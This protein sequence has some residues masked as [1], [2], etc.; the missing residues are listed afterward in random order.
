MVISNC[1]M[2][3]LPID[4]HYKNA[5]IQYRSIYDVCCIVIDGAHPLPVF[6]YLLL[7]R[8]PPPTHKVNGRCVPVGTLLYDERQAYLVW[9]EAW[10]PGRG[11]ILG[12][13][14]QIVTNIF[15]AFHCLVV[16]IA[17]NY[18]LMLCVN[19]YKS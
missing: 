18:S 10:Q 11:R 9:K 17:G 16:L 7:G 1:F 19:I 14:L 6:L 15:I 3:F 13:F 8:S 4:L 12:A 5:D 2:T